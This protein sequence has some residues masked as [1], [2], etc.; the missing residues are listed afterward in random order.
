LA[1][2]RTSAPIAPQALEQP[3]AMEQRQPSPV[4][5]LDGATQFLQTFITRED[6]VEKCQV[7]KSDQD[8]A[9]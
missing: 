3:V 7:W 4:S 8:A 9:K 6:E 2:T 5:P 1:S